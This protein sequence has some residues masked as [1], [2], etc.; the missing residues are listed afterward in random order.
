M[1]DIAR[2]FELI[3]RF[4]D[5][6]QASEHIV[7]GIGDDAAVTEVPPGYQLVTATDTLVATTHFEPDADPVSIGHRSLAV[8]LSDLAAMGA[9]PRWV[10]L[11]LTIPALDESWLEDFASGFFALAERT[12]VTLIGGDTVRG[13][14]AITVTVQ[15]LVPHGTAITRAGATPGD[16]LYVT[17]YPGAAAFARSHPDHELAH[18][19]EFPEPRLEA[20]D[21]LRGIASAMIDISDGLDSDIRQLLQASNVGADIDLHRLPVAASIDSQLGFLAGAELAMFGG[22]D[23]ELLFAVSGEHR[24]KLREQINAWTVPVT[25][26]G[27]VVAADGLRWLLDKGV[28][29]PQQQEF[30]HFV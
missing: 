3:R 16:F 22:E 30:R 12:G 7:L 8:N 9:E 10:S 4:F 18:C 26:I 28:Y 17:G 24:R 11:A 19:F 6:Q 13:P 25:E 1:P 27:K 14:L 15:G 2:E 23:Y 29:T 5:R 21:A 20:G